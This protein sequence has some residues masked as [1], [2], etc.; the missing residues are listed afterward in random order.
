MNE[1]DIFT[2]YTKQAASLIFILTSFKNIHEKAR[3]REMITLLIAAI[4]VLYP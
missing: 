4:V 1:L 2:K 3:E